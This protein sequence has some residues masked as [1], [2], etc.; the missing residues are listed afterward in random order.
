MWLAFVTS[1]FLL[2]YM[3]PWRLGAQRQSWGGK[4]LNRAEGEKAKE[5]RQ[6]SR[7]DC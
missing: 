3:I 2:D 6:M 1:K 4:E 7:A 5:K